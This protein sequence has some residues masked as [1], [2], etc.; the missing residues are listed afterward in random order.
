[1]LLIDHLVL[2]RYKVESQI[3]VGGMGIVYRAHDTKLRRDVALKVIAPHLVEDEG[4]RVRFLHEAQALA[5]LSHPNIVTVFDLA[6][7]PE[8]GLV[9]IV[10]ELLNGLPLR[11]RITD[12]TRPPFF[13]MTVQ[14]CRALEHAHSHGVLHRDIKPENIFACSDGTV[15]LM[16]F[17][18]AR[19]VDGAAVAASGLVTGTISYM[20]PEQLRG[21]ALDPRSDLYALGVLFYEYLC[22]FTPFCSDSPG[23]TLLK[24]L[25]EAPPSLRARVPSVSDEL[26]ALI[27]RLLSK[28][29]VGRYP[30]AT[31]LRE[32]LERISARG[33]T[34][35]TPQ[36]AGPVTSV[37]SIPLVVPRRKGS[38]AVPMRPY[39]TAQ[40]VIGR[41]VAVFC[42]V[43]LGA[44]IAVAFGETL[45]RMFGPNPE[46]PKKT[47][48]AKKSSGHKPK[49]SNRSS[50]RRTR[51]SRRWDSSSSGGT[52][53]S[54]TKPDTDTTAKATDG[55]TDGATGS[56][57]KP[58]D[59]PP[60]DGKGDTPD[61]ANSGG[62]TTDNKD[63]TDS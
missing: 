16:D 53:G 20:S 28:D 38:Q 46:P 3:G 2:G 44:I 39:R 37:T 32:S 36:V 6:E 42:V 27:M 31:I 15:K 50:G 41:F 12:P 13:D 59:D 17:G 33:F 22:G 58:R 5:G 8:T 23:T 18:L 30:S 56:D 51:R 34:V 61:P 29:P 19:L 21:G 9:F 14:V 24:H 49:T 11:K 55:T 62:T 63:G 35:V 40:K 45:Q 48:I 25:T 43:L 7:E 57:E 60:T 1:V 10:M 4:A 47:A 52:G 54:A 26:E